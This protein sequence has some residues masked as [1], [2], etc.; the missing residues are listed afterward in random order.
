MRVRVFVIGANGYLGSAIARRLAKT[1]NAVT[2]LVR[3]PQRAEALAAAGVSLVGGD[4]ADPDS[5]APALR[6]ADVV[7]QA[8]T[9]TDAEKLDGL[10]LEALAAVARAPAEGKAGHLRRVIYTSG[11]WNYGDTGERV[12]DEHSAQDPLAIC[13]W[14]PEHEAKALDLVRHHVEVV[15]FQ[16]GNVYGES[17][18]TFGW[19]FGMARDQREVRI[20]GN[21]SQHW[22]LVHRDDAAEAYRLAA[23]HPLP[24]LSGRPGQRE[25]R[26]HRYVLTDGSDLTARQIVEAIARATGVPAREWPRE[27]VVSALG[28]YGAALLAGQRC[29]ATRARRDLGWTARHTSFVADV[30]SIYHEWLAGHGVSV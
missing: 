16:L 9:G 12:I 30:E 8:A 28:D 19:F 23:E 7:V 25:A 11:I 22:P 4:I 27:Q 24:R 6:S 18:G 20:P 10:V 29:V 5:Y 2:G 13:A 21:G 26:G 3:D 17:R 1:G 15:V 14:R